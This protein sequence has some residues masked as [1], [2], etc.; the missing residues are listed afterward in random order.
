MGIREKLR[1]N[2]APHLQAGETVQAVFSAQRTSQWWAV[3][4]FWIMILKDSYRA[5][6]VTDRRILLCRSGR[7]SMSPVNEVLRELPRSTRLGPASGLWYRS[8]NLGE[9][10]YIHK[11]FHKD[12]AAADGTSA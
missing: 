11:R 9:R 12:I 2:A 10:L 7:I 4:S 6:V 3:V 5:V 1:T 8:E